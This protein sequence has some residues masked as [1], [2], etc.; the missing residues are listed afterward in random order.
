MFYDKRLGTHKGD[1]NCFSAL[2]KPRIDNAGSNKSNLH[3]GSSHPVNYPEF[4]LRK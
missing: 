2:L 1:L 3:V 4:Q